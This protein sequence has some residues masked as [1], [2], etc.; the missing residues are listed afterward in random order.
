M[1]TLSSAVYFIKSYNTY[2]IVAVRTFTWNT[3]E[4]SINVERERDTES[5]CNFILACISLRLKL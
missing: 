3:G 4:Q 2:N 1:R 5:P